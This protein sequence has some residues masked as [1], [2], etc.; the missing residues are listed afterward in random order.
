ML[1][2]GRLS[3]KDPNTILWVIQP[4]HDRNDVAV[5]VM[6]SPRVEGPE[7]GLLPR[8]DRHGRPLPAGPMPW[9]E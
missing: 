8:T 1:M 5:T 7:A 3:A 2:P 4:E 6:E 9:L